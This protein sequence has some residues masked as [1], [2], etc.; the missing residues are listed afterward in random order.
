MVPAMA[1]TVSVVI[2]AFNTE[3]YVGAAIESCLAQTLRDIEVVVVDDGSSDS[4]LEVARRYESD[5]R[6]R[7]I[8]SA[9]N[10]G[11]SHARNLALDAASGDWVAVLDSDDTMLPDRLEVIVEGGR[12]YRAEMVGDDLLLVHDGETEPYATLFELAGVAGPKAMLIDLDDVVDCETGGSSKLRLGLTQPVVRRDFLEKH[13]IR[14]DTELAVGED[15]LVY[16]ECLLAGAT[17]VMLPSAHYRYR[18]RPMSA[19]SSSQRDTVERKLH[20]CESLLA[21][22]LPA[23]ARRSLERYRRNLRR[24]LGYQQVVEAMKERRPIAAARSAV[25]QPYTL[26]RAGERLPGVVKRRFDYYVRRDTHAFDMLPPVKH[27]APR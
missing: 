6:V 2:A 17:W 12:A 26:L 23:D 21:R 8:A 11:A 3:C 20:T 25:T 4:T 10:R 9:D 15:F 18:Q 24:E 16:L 7:V 27:G 19:V 14:Y 1:P 5:P 22:P 13:G